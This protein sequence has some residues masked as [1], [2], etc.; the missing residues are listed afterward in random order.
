MNGV[1]NFQKHLLDP[2]RNTNVA[3]EVSATI[4]I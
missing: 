4:W 1:A 3:K 2:R